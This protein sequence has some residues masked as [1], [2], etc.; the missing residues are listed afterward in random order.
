MLWYAVLRDARQIALDYAYLYDHD[1]D[2]DVFQDVIL[3]QWDGDHRDWSDHVTFSTHSR[4]DD[5]GHVGSRLVDG[6]RGTGEDS[7]Y[8]LKLSR[9]V[10]L[11]DDR[12]PTVWEI[13]DLV[14]DQVHEVHAH[15]AGAQLPRRRWLRR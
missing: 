5:H 1:G 2:R 3:G 10:G 8:G 13:N 12:L 7:I 11:L 15:L 4:L 6:G 9:D 14:L